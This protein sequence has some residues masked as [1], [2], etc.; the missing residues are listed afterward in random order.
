MNKISMEVP[1]ANNQIHKP[2]LEN[3]LLLFDHMDANFYFLLQTHRRNFCPK[4]HTHPLKYC[5]LDVTW[6]NEYIDGVSI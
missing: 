4:G 6:V 3:F 2:F 1:T 5:L